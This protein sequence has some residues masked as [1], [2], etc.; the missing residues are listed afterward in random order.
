MGGAFGVFNP[1]KVQVAGPGVLLQSCIGKKPP[2]R[3]S[4]HT[5]RHSLF[6]VAKEPKPPTPFPASKGKRS[7]RAP[8]DA[9]RPGPRTVINRWNEA[10]L[11]M[12]DCLAGSRA[13]TVGASDGLQIDKFCHFVN[14]AKKAGLKLE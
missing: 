14:T 13:D 9:E 5:C 6:L 10:V 7:R 11:R 1:D 8:A 2:A 4:C 3:H 12:A